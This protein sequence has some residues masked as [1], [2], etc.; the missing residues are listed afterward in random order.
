LGNW[1]VILDVF[2][3]HT[4]FRITFLTLTIVGR[5]RG[6][7][8]S[9]QDIFQTFGFPESQDGRVLSTSWNVQF[10]AFNTSEKLNNLGQLHK[11]YVLIRQEETNKNRSQERMLLFLIDSIRWYFHMSNIWF[12]IRHLSFPTKIYGPKVFLLNKIKP[13]YSDILYNP[14]H[15]PGSLVCLIRQVPLYICFPYQCWY[16]GRYVGRQTYF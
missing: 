4:S 9:H 7:V 13:E 15:F 11:L 5:S 6:D 3:R 8:S 14:T 16:V 2:A 1:N 10:V 12:A